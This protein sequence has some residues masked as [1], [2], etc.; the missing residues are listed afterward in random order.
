MR[1]RCRA[2]PAS[3]DASSDRASF[4]CPRIR[5]ARVARFV[6]SSIVRI[7]WR[8]FHGIWSPVRFHC[9]FSVCLVHQFTPTG[10]VV[11]RS[12]LVSTTWTRDSALLVLDLHI[13][14]SS[15]RVLNNTNDRGFGLA[16]DVIN[17]HI[18]NASLIRFQA[19]IFEHWISDAFHTTS[20]AAAASSAIS[21]SLLVRGGPVTRSRR[22]RERGPIRL[23]SIAIDGI[24]GL[25]RRCSNALIRLVAAHRIRRTTELQCVFDRRHGLRVLREASLE[26]SAKVGRR[27][28]FGNHLQTFVFDIVIVLRAQTSSQ[29]L[30]NVDTSCRT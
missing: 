18:R 22:S 28:R 29:I 1:C 19:R 3:S 27:G 24:Q 9:P 13:D 14:I 6:I 21:R 15:K 8:R 2:G 16:H 12:S 23:L 17:R 20:T 11:V 5:I 7:I 10:R 26:L 4:L 30:G 25:F